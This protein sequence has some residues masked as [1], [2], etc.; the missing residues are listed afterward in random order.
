MPRPSPILVLLH[1]DELEILLV[2][3]LSVLYIQVSQIPFIPSYP[4]G[5]SA[6]MACM[7]GADIHQV[8][9]ISGSCFQG[10]VSVS[11]RRS[12]RRARTSVTYCRPSRIGM[13]FRRSLS[14]GS[15]IQPSMGIALSVKSRD[16]IKCK[17]ETRFK[18]RN[19]GC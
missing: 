18:L 9:L 15:L 14:V 19:E 16:Q 1:D 12:A 13:R 7:H 3:S 2:W 17:H 5:N 8:I 11:P 10:E 6:H 4:P